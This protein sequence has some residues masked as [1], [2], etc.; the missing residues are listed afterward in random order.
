M[1]GH[2]ALIVAFFVAA[3]GFALAQTRPAFTGRAHFI[4]TIA[5][6]YRTTEAFGEIADL[7]GLQVKYYS[8]R[9]GIAAVRVPLGRAPGTAR[10]L[11]A[12]DHRVRQVEPDAL[13]YPARQ[14]PN[15]PLFPR[16]WALF[17]PANGRADV[18]AQEA[19]GI[20]RGRSHVVIGIIDTGIDYLHPDLAAHM[21]I[22]EDEVPGNGRDDDN[23]GYV[24]DVHG[25]DFVHRRGDPRD[26]HYHGTVMAGIAG[27][28]THNEEGIAGVMHDVSLMAV[29]GLGST[30]Y[31]F[32]SDL[33]ACIYYAVDNG[34][35]VINASWGSARYTRALY[36]AIAYA[37]AHDVIFVAAAGNWRRDNDREPFYP[38]SYDLDN[39][40]SVAASDSLDSLASFSH[41]GA[42]TVDLAAPGA[43]V[44]STYPGGRYVRTSGTSMA[45]PHV[46][47]CIGLCAAYAPG[48]RYRE[49][50]A[51]VL[52][53]VEPLF[54]L[55]GRCVSGGRLDIH[56]ALRQSVF[57]RRDTRFALY[58]LT[59]AILDQRNTR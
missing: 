2:A 44:I 38:A 22:N 36:D 14:F 32:T 9:H 8:A 54:H 26:D 12:A 17:N 3:N 20:T 46:A 45:A 49:H 56:R 53:S 34:A 29:K 50:T 18:K 59:T 11:L 10:Q 37:G 47:A 58:Y 1:S 40:L 55:R 25:Y 6:G 52:Q 28:V 24:D 5:P 7:Y 42:A 51:L 13:M 21:W 4:L 43:S 41:W 30:G 33:I 57:R 16:Q 23:N 31:G 27:A 19:W 39:I 15:D 48:L 35:D